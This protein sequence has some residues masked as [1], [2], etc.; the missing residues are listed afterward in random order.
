MELKE[1]LYTALKIQKQ[2]RELKDKQ[3]ACKWELIRLIRGY[4]VGFDYTSIYFDFIESQI[5]DGD[6]IHI[7]IEFKDEPELLKATQLSL[8]KNCRCSGGTLTEDIY[9]FKDSIDSLFLEED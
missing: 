9:L 7:E 3:E 4:L 2:K 8:F 5:D 6:Y 1:Q